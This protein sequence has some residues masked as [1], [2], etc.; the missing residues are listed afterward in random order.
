MYR[1]NK[2]YFGVLLE[3][4]GLDSIDSFSS[5]SRA[6]AERYLEPQPPAAWCFRVARGVAVDHRHRHAG[7]RSARPRDERKALPSIGVA[8]RS[9][10]RN[11]GCGAL[12]SADEE[13]AQPRNQTP[14]V[15]PLPGRRAA[16]VATAL[17]A[18][19]GC[20][21]RNFADVE[22]GAA[23]EGGAGVGSSGRA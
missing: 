10:L 16:A 19:T 21:Q 3:L 13:E 12:A 17:A 18:S 20:P 1:D 6:T 4:D 11:G 5:E 14:A 9:E 2:S 7:Q 8:A 23:V 22:P 15:A